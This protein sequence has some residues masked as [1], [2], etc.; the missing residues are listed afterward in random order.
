MGYRY[1][2]DMGD[3]VM[4]RAPLFH[5]ALWLQPQLSPSSQ[6]DVA[7]D[8]SRVRPLWPRAGYRL[9]SKLGV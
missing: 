3:Q 4:L 5:G 6:R 1:T 2:S 9:C 7:G 8:A